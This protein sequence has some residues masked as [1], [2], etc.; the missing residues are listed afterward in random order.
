MSN[1]ITGWMIDNVPVSFF[2]D[3]CGNVVEAGEVF[4][5]RQVPFYD[6]NTSSFCLLRCSLLCVCQDCL[7]AIIY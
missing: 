5:Y 3:D 4:F 2:C 1:L 7:A 6:I